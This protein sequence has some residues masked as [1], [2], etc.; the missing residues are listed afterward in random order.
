MNG[1]I[2]KTYPCHVNPRK[3]IAFIYV[4]KIGT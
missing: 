2:G 4:V 1:V 3:S